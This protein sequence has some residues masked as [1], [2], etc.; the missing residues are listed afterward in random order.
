[1][2]YDCSVHLLRLSLNS[3]VRYDLRLLLPN[4]RSVWYLVPIF[5]PRVWPIRYSLCKF[6]LRFASIAWTGIRYP[7]DLRFLMTL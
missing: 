5:L 3:F 7:S 6:V 4:G 2:R 1:M